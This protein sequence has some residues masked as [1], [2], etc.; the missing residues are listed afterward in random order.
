MKQY[1]NITESFLYT[2]NISSNTNWKCTFLLKR[3]WNSNKHHTVASPHQY[4]GLLKLKY[5][6]YMSMCADFI[7]KKIKKIFTPFWSNS[8]FIQ[9]YYTLHPINMSMLSPLTFH[10]H[11]DQFLTIINTSVKICCQFKIDKYEE[12]VIIGRYQLVRKI[13]N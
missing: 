11:V 3:D 5:T 6:I 9:I 1:I 7:L 2:T 12:K 13:K 4:A 10:I 8:K